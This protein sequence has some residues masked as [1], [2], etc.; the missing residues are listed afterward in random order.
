MSIL[1]SNNANSTVAGP[2]SSVAT[3]VNVASGGGAAFPSPTNPG[4]YFCV[5]FYDQLTKTRT[6][7]CHC[8]ARNADTLTLQRAQEG[9]AAQAWSAGDLIG[10]LVTA[11]SLMN[12]VQAGTGPASTS[13]LYVGTDTSSTVNAVVA[14]T[15]PVPANLAIGM[16]F[17]IKIA[18]TNTGAATAK[19]NGGAVIPIVRQD[20]SAMV[21][22]E[23][24]AAEDMIFVYN[25]VSFNAMTPANLG[26][27]KQ[28]PKDVDGNCQIYCRPD[29]DDN[30][31]G[32]ANTPQHACK[33]IAGCL[34]LFTGAYYLPISDVWINCIGGT[35]YGG[36]YDAGGCVNN[37]HII[38]DEVTPGNC[39]WDVTQGTGY[40]YPAYCD[41]YRC[42][43]ATGTS[44]FEVRGFH[45][46]SYQE[47]CRAEGGQVDLHNCWHEPP[48]FEA[49]YP[50]Y[51]TAHG[52]INCYDTHQF[53]PTANPCLGWWGCS[54]G[55]I[56]Y[57]DEV[58]ALPCT[59]NL[60]A[61]FVFQTAFVV[62]IS[63]ATITCPGPTLL[64][65]TGF[66]NPPCPKY[67]CD[68]G[69]GLTLKNCVFPGTLPGIVTNPGWVT[70]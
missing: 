50:C 27:S 67:H 69:G 6:E 30:N 65:F 47:H 60:T 22:K 66:A 15:V 46:K 5:T 52:I 35:Y 64:Q 34:R 33:T 24:T 68:T 3:V 43:Y 54:G 19:F 4:D 56:K 1:F 13:I 21:G 45:F 70:I 49:W 28:P 10:N 44:R 61:S 26:N 37:W 20:G 23:L 48:I 18:N 7:I 14:A 40:P 12:F 53:I 38:G 9:T 58:K 51:A 39:V 42:V 63:N 55:Q 8:T 41:Q 2:I 57:G 16:Q 29:G 62:V 11:G 59:L 25:G 31:D 36:C 32:S 17:N